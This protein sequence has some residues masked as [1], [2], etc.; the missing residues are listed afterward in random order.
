LL[1]TVPSARIAAIIEQSLDYAVQRELE[2]RLSSSFLARV[3]EDEA[4]A[5]VV[6]GLKDA[7]V[8][9]GYE[10]IPTDSVLEDAKS[11]LITLRAC[12][13]RPERIVPSADG[14]MAFTF[15]TSGDR[16]AFIEVLN[17]G[18]ISAVLYSTTGDS[19]M[20]P[21]VSSKDASGLRSAIEALKA[22][23]EVGPLAAT[24]S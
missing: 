19:R 12:R 7:A 15:D 18:E 2:S 6:D 24:A 3:Y 23:F 14:G 8:R 11:I 5:E 17:E 21:I 16:R 4:D 20:I 13:V 1:T 10:Q 22:H 9:L